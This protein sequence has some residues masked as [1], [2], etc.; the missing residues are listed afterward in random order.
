MEQKRAH[1]AHH[2]PLF[3]R[4]GSVAD[5]VALSFVALSMLLFCLFVFLIGY[6][7]INT[8]GASFMQTSRVAH[9]TLLI[10]GKLAAV[11]ISNVS[12][13]KE[14]FPL[15]TAFVFFLGFAGT[16]FQLR[17][18]QVQAIRSQHQRDR[19]DQWRK[20]EFIS[21]QIR[22]FTQDRS[23]INA[24]RILEAFD[25][26][27]NARLDLDV[28]S[29]EDLDTTRSGL[30]TRVHVEMSRQNILDGLTPDEGTETYVPFRQI[31]T[32]EVNDMKHAHTPR[33]NMI[34]YEM[35][36]FLSYFV[37]FHKFVRD[38]IVS[39]DDL[40]Q[41][42][43]YWLNLIPFEPI[44]DDWGTLKPP[45]RLRKM[46]QEYLKAYYNGTDADRTLGVCYLLSKIVGI[47]YDST[48]FFVPGGR[49][50]ENNSA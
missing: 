13:V 3:R 2:N 34:A 26:G 23:V 44:S 31:D 18:A 25:A 8:H 1:V 41:Y 16:V 38:G 36:T 48:A 27:Y 43:Y 12:N 37:H 32:G 14:L 10:D 45:V 30:V 39:H 28:V 15:V 11:D 6:V 42:L 24:K 20:T 5:A 9:E 7:W 49:P 35:D 19:E 50:R 22:L 46:F 33:E 21:T 47:P 29:P 17:Q 40:Q 4:F